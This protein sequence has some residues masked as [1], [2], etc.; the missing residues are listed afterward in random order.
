[1]ILLAPIVLLLLLVLLV[2]RRRSLGP[3]LRAAARPRVAGRRAPALPAAVDDAVDVA[4][5]DLPDAG[6]DDPVDDGADVA[7]VAD[8][9]VPLE[10]GAEYTR[11][12]LHARLGGGLHDVLPHVRGRVVCGCFD[13]RRNPHAP[14]VVLPGFGPGI[15]RWAHVFATQREAVPC[16]LRRPGK[17]WEYVGDYRVRALSQDPDE[18]EEWSRLSG[19]EGTVSM[20]LHL[21]EADAPHDG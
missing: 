10:F 18:I 3:A 12:E 17:R 11:Q 1:M 19:R 8:G 9:P 4:V 21:E 16:F 15:E 13:V 5:D 14:F 6:A 2:P 7:A 20:V